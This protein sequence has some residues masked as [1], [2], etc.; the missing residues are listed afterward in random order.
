MFT[1]VDY[2]MVNVSDMRRSIAFYRDALGLSLKS[3]SSGWSEFQTGETT[4]ALHLAA[5]PAP[6]AGASS[7]GP[8]AGTCSIGFSVEN[9]DRIYAELQSRGVRF[10]MPPTDQREEGI[11]LVAAIDPDGLVISFASPLPA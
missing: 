3:E 4:L 11:R 9:V 1:R 7:K 10:L 8:A 6:A 2:I 5:S